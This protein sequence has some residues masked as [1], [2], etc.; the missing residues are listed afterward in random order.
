MIT[1]AQRYLDVFNALMEMPWVQDNVTATEA[2]AILQIRWSA[3]YSIELSK[4]MAQKPWVQDGV[5][6]AET[7]AMWG[8]AWTIREAPALAE[9]ILQKSWVQDGITRDEGI[10]IRNLSSLAR[11]TDEATQQRM[12]DVATGI[13]GMPF[14]DDV[15]FAEARAVL[16]LY[17]L[18]HRR[19]QDSFR[20]I[21]S[22]PKV[23]DGITDQEA[24]VIAVLRTPAYYKPEAIPHLLDG[25]HGTDGVYLE[26]RII[27]LPLTGETLLTIVRTQDHTTASMDYLEHAVRFAENLIDAPLP[28]NYVAL[29]F[30]ALGPNYGANNWWTHMAMRQSI[31]GPEEYARTVAHEVGH[32]Y[33]RDSSVTWINEGT[34]NIMHI[35]AEYERTGYPHWTHT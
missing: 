30:G 34:A 16:S 14:L 27:Q 11:R 22:H 31:D 25:M 13:V 2:K 17:W 6:T 12:T 7:D 10:I 33:F 19:Y 1:A 29:Y 20:T 24:K 5:T 3:H 15:T 9:R 8:L 26:E 32:Y 23:Q 4:Q 28:T 35:L 18:S 21:M